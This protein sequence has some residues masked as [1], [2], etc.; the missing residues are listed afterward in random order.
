[1]SPRLAE[2]EEGSVVAAGSDAAGLAGPLWARAPTAPAPKAEAI[3]R[4][5]S[6]ILVNWN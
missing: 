1:L 2:S 4:G 3:S 6:R 5:S